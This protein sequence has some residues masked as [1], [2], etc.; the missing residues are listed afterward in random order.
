MRN[1]SEQ[2]S[3][4]RSKGVEPEIIYM[5]PDLYNRLGRPHKFFGVMVDCD[6]RIKT[7]FEVR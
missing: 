4:M 5:S 7:G 2:I 3:R 6:N 1:I